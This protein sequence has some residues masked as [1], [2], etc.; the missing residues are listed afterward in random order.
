M[1]PD[2]RHFG[3]CSERSRTVKFILVIELQILDVRSIGGLTGSGRHGFT[4]SDKEG[5]VK[6]RHNQSL[7]KIL[8]DYMANSPFHNLFTR[9]FF[10]S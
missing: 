1:H 5:P 9:N 3:T 4:S 8:R 10:L 2:E 7:C 6:N